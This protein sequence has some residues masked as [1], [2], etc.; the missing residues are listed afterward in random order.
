MA[1]METLKQRRRSRRLHEG[2]KKD[3]AVAY[4]DDELISTGKD[5]DRARTVGPCP[6]IPR[7]NNLNQTAASEFG[8]VYQ[9]SAYSDQY[10][11]ENDL[12]SLAYTESDDGTADSSDDCSTCRS[13]S[14]KT[15]RCV[16]NQNESSTNND[17]DN[18]INDKPVQHCEVGKYMAAREM[19][20]L[21]ERM[22]ALTVL[23]ST[24][25]CVMFFLSGSWLSQSFIEAYAKGMV[26]DDGFDS[27]QCITSS[28]FPHLHA[29]P[30][31]PPLAAAIGI[32]CHAPF[33]M[34]YHWKYAHRLPPGLP[35]TNH[36][37]RRMD[38]AMIHFCC[39]FMAYSSTGDWNFFLANALFNMDCFYRQFLREVRPRRNQ[40]RIGMSIVF[41]TM[42]LLKR[43]EYLAY[44][45]LAFLFAVGGWLFG[46]YPIGGWSHSAFHIVMTFVPP[47]MFSAALDLSSSQS[48]LEVAAH[49][50]ILAD[51][52]FLS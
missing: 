23:P 14:T 25:Y 20:P 27:S 17:I 10:G 13:R 15:R 36:W 6:S 34:I 18:Y 41:Y 3:S 49:C 35:R 1:E 28:W 32:L 40:V 8:M 33:S 37:S 46:Q 26:D 44:C 2:G 24:F 50:A 7:R 51:E 16:R 11:A 9:E 30:P 39:A 38:Q 45:Q 21:Q 19:T 52:N 4:S 29:L 31:L 12:A 22:N 43:G 48:R 42:P 5:D 47:V